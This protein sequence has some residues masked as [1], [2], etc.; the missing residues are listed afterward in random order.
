MWLG[1]ES[2]IAWFQYRLPESDCPV[3]LRINSNEEVKVV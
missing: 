1:G 2:V 3:A